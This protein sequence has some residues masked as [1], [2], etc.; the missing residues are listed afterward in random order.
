MNN[1]SCSIGLISVF[2]S[3]SACGGGGSGLTSDTDALS[4]T[5]STGA[6]APAG[7][8]SLKWVAPAVRSDGNPLSLSELDSYTVHFGTSID[9]YPYSVSIEDSSATSAD[10]PDLPAGTYYVVITVTDSNGLESA[11]SGVAVKEVS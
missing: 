8:L 5:N 10:I 3:L 4:S 2:L 11:P 7:T 6:V 9:E 1:R